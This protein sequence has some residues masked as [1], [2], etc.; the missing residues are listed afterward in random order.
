MDQ[1]QC[2]R[3][4]F[5]DNLVMYRYHGSDCICVKN[6]IFLNKAAAKIRKQAVNC[7]CNYAIVMY[8]TVPDR[9][10][11]SVSEILR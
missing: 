6:Q 5:S 10:A 2:G 1:E 4:I 7:Y 8:H 9:F 3:L 11:Y